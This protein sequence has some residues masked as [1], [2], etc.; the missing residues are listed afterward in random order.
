LSCLLSLGV[1]RVDPFLKMDLI[2]G[3]KSRCAV[4]M[5][6]KSLLF[7]DYV[8]ILQAIL[9]YDMF[10]EYNRVLWLAFRDRHDR[11][12]KLGEFIEFLRSNSLMLV[13]ERLVGQLAMRGIGEYDAIYDH[14]MSY[15]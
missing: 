11:H 7:A 3:R 2:C 15:S 4:T 8:V 6:S 13:F 9:P 14:L 10:P 5:D 12:I 1:A